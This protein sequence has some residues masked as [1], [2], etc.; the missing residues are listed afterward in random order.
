[1]D[2]L[3]AGGHYDHPYRDRGTRFGSVCRRVGH[4]RLSKSVDLS[5]SVSDSSKTDGAQLVAW[6]IPQK[7]ILDV[8]RSCDGKSGGRRF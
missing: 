5:Y 2:K 8:G 6:P 4:R 3:S 1:M 7:R